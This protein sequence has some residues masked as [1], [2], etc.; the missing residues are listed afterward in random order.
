[1]PKNEGPVY[2]GRLHQL[3]GHGG[4]VIA[5]DQGGDGDAIHHVHQDQSRDGTVQVHRLQSL[6]QWD[7]DALVRD[8]HAKQEGG[9]RRWTERR[10]Q[11]R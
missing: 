7:E 11:R 5:K 2:A 8:E 10:P 1:M 6:H 4:I 3:G 9:K